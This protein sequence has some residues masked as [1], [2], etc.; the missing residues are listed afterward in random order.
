MV[1]R[2][3]AE[4]FISEVHSLSLEEIAKDYFD[5]F[6]SRSVVAPEQLT[7]SGEVRSRFMT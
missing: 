4:G 6:V 5:G 1:R 3:E 2:W 7:S